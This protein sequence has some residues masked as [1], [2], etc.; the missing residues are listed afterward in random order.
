[1]ISSDVLFPSQKMF[2]KQLL[3]KQEHEHETSQ[4]G[5]LMWFATT[6]FPKGSLK[7]SGACQGQHCMPR[8]QCQQ[9][10]C[11]D[12]H[13]QGHQVGASD[14]VLNEGGVDQMLSLNGHHGLII[15]MV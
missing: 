9:P 11:S 12:I 3:L 6:N 8:V 7:T 2:M 4:H 5:D 10:F 15:N 1:M 14:L 13:G